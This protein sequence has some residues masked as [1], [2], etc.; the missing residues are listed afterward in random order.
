MKEKNNH[1]Y[2]T[3]FNLLRLK[4]IHTENYSIQ[5]NYR[6]SRKNSNTSFINNKYSILIRNPADN[7]LYNRININ[8]LVKVRFLLEKSIQNK[9]SVSN[10]TSHI[11]FN[12]KNII[13]DNDSNSADFIKKNNIKKTK[14]YKP[15]YSKDNYLNNTMGNKFNNQY[16]KELFKVNHNYNN[17]QIKFHDGFKDYLEG[18]NSSISSAITHTKK[19]KKKDK[20]KSIWQS[21]QKIKIN[22]YNVIDRIIF[23]QSFWRSYYLRKLL[24]RGLEKYYSSIA[25]IKYI[26]NIIYNN[27]KLLFQSFIESIKEFILMKKFVSL[28]DKISK[29]NINDYFNGNDESI[30]IFGIPKNKKNDFIYFFIN[31]EKKKNNTYKN[32]ITKNEIYKNP[33]KSNI[34]NIKDYNSKRSKKYKGNNNIDIMNDKKHSK[35]IKSQNLYSKINLMKKNNQK[36]YC[37]GHLGTDVSFQKNK[38]K[39]LIN[40]KLYKKKN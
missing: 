28:N 39:N 4:E 35:Y 14:N 31:R 9:S 19:N 22:N 21:N 17:F 40:Q 15:K 20:Y 12:K 8:K 18:K 33:S 25:I 27:K 1:F 37:L 3:N 26:N 5:A 23:I 30:N 13:N 34:L 6:A 2:Q 24:A 29:E 32:N 10:L 7:F 11:S 16:K 36:N 38:N